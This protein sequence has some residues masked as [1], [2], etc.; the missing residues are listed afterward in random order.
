MLGAWI[1]NSSNLEFDKKG[2]ITGINFNHESFRASCRKHFW[3]LINMKVTPKLQATVRR[4]LV[5]KKNIILQQQRSDNVGFQLRK[6]SNM[7]T[8][9]SMRVGSSLETSTVLDDDES[10]SLG[11]S[12]DDNTYV[13]EVE[14]DDNLKQALRQKEKEGEIS[15]QD[16]LAEEV[17]EEILMGPLEINVGDDDREVEELLIPDGVTLSDTVDNLASQPRKG[18]TYFTSKG[19]KRR[20]TTGSLRSTDSSLPPLEYASGNRSKLS[21]GSG[22]KTAAGMDSISINSKSDLGKHSTNASLKSDKNT[23]IILLGEE[24]A[25]EVV[26]CGGDLEKDIS[27]SLRSEEIN[28]TVSPH[29]QK[30]DY[31]EDREHSQLNSHADSPLSREDVVQGRKLS[32]VEQSGGISDERKASRLSNV[33]DASVTTDSDAQGKKLSRVLENSVESGERRS[34]QL[35]GSVDGSPSQESATQSRKLSRVMNDKSYSGGRK[36]S[37]LNSHADSP[38]SRED[39]VQGRKLSRVEQS[40]GISDERKASRLSNVVDA[41]VTTDSDAQGR[42]LSR[43]LENSVESGERRSSQ[44]AGS[45]DG[46]PSQESAT[47]SRKLSRVMNDKSYS[48][49]RKQSQL[50]SHADSPLSREDVVQ[51]RKSSRVEQSGGISDERKASRLSNVVDASVTTDSDAQG[52]KLSRVLENSVESGERRSS[53]LA[54]SVDGSPSQ[55]SA[56]QSRKLSRV[57]ND[58]SYSGGRKQSQLNSHADSPLSREDVVQGRKSSRVEQSG[59]IS[60]ERKASRLSNIVDDSATTDSDAQGRK[61]SRVL[62]NSVESGER[63]SSQLA[64]S[65]DGSPSQESATQSRKLSRVMNDKSYSGG[66]KQSQLNSHA[67]SPLSCED[68]V[69]GR[70][71]SRVEESGGISDERKASRLSNVVDAS[72]TTDSDA[73]GRK[74]SRVLENSVESGERRSSQLAGSVD[75]SPSQESATQSRKLS[76]VMNDKSY[77]GGRKQSQL[78]S[79]ADSPLSREDVVQ[80]RKLSRVEESG[81]ISDERK[82]SRLSN[83]VDASVTTDS[84]AQGRKLSRVLENSVESGE[85]RSLQ[86]TGSVDG[87][88]SQESA[89][90]SRKLSRVMNDKS[91]SGGRK[92]SQLNSHADS[93]LSCEDVVQ[94]RKLSRVEESGGIS[95]ER[96]ASRLSNIVDDSATTDSDA[97]GRKLSRVLE[98]SVESG[99]RRSSQLAGS[100][101]GS[102]SQESATQSRK[103]SRVMN[104]KSYSG[105]RKQSQLN[106]HADSPLSCEDVVQGRKL[107]RVE[108]SGGISDERKASRLS[109]VVDASVTTDSDAQGRK[110]SRVLENSVESGERRSLQLTG[111]VDGSPSQESATQSR[112]LSRVMNDKSYS[113]G[114]KQSQLNSHADSPLSRED[115]VQGRKLSRVEESGG[116]SD[117]RKASRLSN[118][119]DASVTT[120]SDAQGRKLSRVLENSV[121]SG[122]R[123][124]S[125]LAGSVD[126]SPSQES[127]TQ[128]RKLSRVMN[129]KSYSGGRK[130]SQ[131]NSHADSPLSREDVVQGRKLSR[132]EQSGGIS[133]ERKASRLSNVV[134][135]SVT[136]DSDAQGRKLSRVLENSVESGERRS[137]QLAGSVDGSPSQE[138]ATQSRKLSRVMND[139]SYSGGRKQSQL[140]SHADS[141]LSRE[142]VV[143]GRK[144]SRVE[145]SGGISDERK[146]SRLSNVVDASVTTDSDAQGRKMSRLVSEKKSSLVSGESDHSSPDGCI[147]EESSDF[148]YANRKKSKIN[149]SSPRSDYQNGKKSVSSK[150][151][152][153]MSMQDIIIEQ[154]PESKLGEFLSS[155]IESD[156]DSDYGSDS[157]HEDSEYSL[158]E[159]SA[160]N[161]DLAVE[162]GELREFV[163]TEMTN[164]IGEVG[165]ISSSLKMRTKENGAS[166][167]AETENVTAEGSKEFINENF[168]SM[169]SEI[170][171]LKQLVGEMQSNMAS[172]SPVPHREESGGSEDK[173][174]LQDKGQSDDFSE[175][176]D[177]ASIKITNGDEFQMSGIFP[178]SPAVDGPKYEND[179]SS[180]ASREEKKTS[181]LGLIVEE[182]SD[183]GDNLDA[184]L[185]AEDSLQR[186][187]IYLKPNDNVHQ[188]VKADAVITKFFTQLIEKKR[189][190]RFLDSVLLRSTD[191]SDYSDNSRGLRDICEDMVRCI[192]V[193]VIDVAALLTLDLND[194]FGPL[195]RFQAAMAIVKF[196]PDIAALLVLFIYSFQSIVEVSSESFHCVNG[197][198]RKHILQRELLEAGIITCLL[199]LAHRT[200]NNA[201][202]VCEIIEAILY[203]LAD[204]PDGY[205]YAT[206]MDESALKTFSRL[207]PRLCRKSNRASRKSLSFIYT[208]CIDCPDLIITLEKLDFFQVLATCCYDL[209]NS[210]DMLTTVLCNCM[211]F[212]EQSPDCVHVLNNTGHAEIIVECLIAYAKQNSHE[213]LSHFTVV[214]GLLNALCTSCSTFC[215]SFPVHS[216]LSSIKTCLELKEGNFLF[217][218]ILSTIK[219]LLSHYPW[220]KKKCVFLKYSETL[221]P[222]IMHTGTSSDVKEELLALQRI[223]YPNWNIED[224]EAKVQLQEK[225]TIKTLE[226]SNNTVDTHSSSLTERVFDKQDNTYSSISPTPLLKDDSFENSSERGGH[227]LIP[228]APVSPKPSAERP[229]ARFKRAVSKAHALNVIS[230]VAFPYVSK[231]RLMKMKLN[232]ERLSLSQ[233]DDDS[234]RLDHREKHFYEA[235]KLKRGDDKEEFDDGTNFYDKS[236]RRDSPGANNEENAEKEESIMNTDVNAKSHRLEATSP[237]NNEKKNAVQQ[238]NSSMDNGSVLKPLIAAY[239]S[240]SESYINIL[241]HIFELCKKE[242]ATSNYDTSKALYSRI[243]ILMGGAER[244]VADP[245]VVSETLKVLLFFKFEI[246]RKV[247]ITESYLRILRHI[248]EVHRENS[249]LLVK[250]LSLLNKRSLDY[251]DK[252]FMAAIASAFEGHLD[253]EKFRKHVIKFVL[254]CITVNS[255]LRSIMLESGVCSLILDAYAVHNDKEN[256]EVLVQVILMLCADHSE[257]S[258]FFG[259][260]EANRLYLD[261]LKFYIKDEDIFHLATVPIFYSLKNFNNPDEMTMDES[262]L[263]PIMNLFDMAEKSGDD[264]ARII[265]T[266]LKLIRELCTVPCARKLFMK[267]NFSLVVSQYNTPS[268]ST[269]ICKLSKSISKR[270][271][272]E[273]E[274]GN[275]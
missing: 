238:E 24:R 225:A 89:T 93:P 144:L 180:N 230:K 212:V 241:S 7:V 132:V 250:V 121:E 235:Q 85:R 104:D 233:F 5:R 23:D 213:S 29:S 155:M 208:L 223:I 191:N 53:Q 169:K 8:K 15:R 75:G 202:F 119:V 174:G 139:K 275:K 217:R 147:K 13:G 256:L 86:L 255:S 96:K 218:I 135:A 259:T 33:V 183:C 40:G 78:N 173:I 263:L 159:D 175:S 186:D 240:G 43:V 224:E 222:H 46:S 34:S 48:G 145:Q 247:E 127:A 185:D 199:S 14:E 107:S 140:N 2:K 128:S 150:R 146:A 69:Q 227:V 45:V 149:V 20:G 38:L 176:T 71:L 37:Q 198:I 210:I 243:D 207:L 171:E 95:D 99:E 229:Q 116:I 81:G 63:R 257:N 164:F 22:V 122:E 266:I 179:C 162:I 236:E 124:S 117:E 262:C 9:G 54:G 90:Q 193:G 264:G 103:L 77:S 206:I 201:D 126:G 58:K 92:Q 100:V 114:R 268:F 234:L 167:R 1:L 170:L 221:I 83:V 131:L 182:K 204:M 253:D 273:F 67:D 66:R 219:S 148:S 188:S 260:T 72:V 215:R 216:F 56:T 138:S 187:L 27:M 17:P 50:N 166:R 118:V 160:A 111:S 165:A 76:R 181:P 133:D 172:N 74:L 97:Q 249:D 125:Q 136:T 4:F 79:H 168:E 98:N 115:V 84:D 52:R 195:N 152:P 10:K 269:K 32:R 274:K 68:V 30:L 151:K 101:D 209:V 88:P 246:K 44:L 130:Q 190:R 55:E 108:E 156:D 57:M 110:L 109:N 184:L 3:L 272:R 244:H 106:S 39:V 82:A 189:R 220:L 239:K 161:Q 157:G 49:G 211:L 158:P 252:K 245:N 11:S 196:Y 36:Q 41:S 35:A 237:N 62:E 120:D 65:V 231:M 178:L 102:P 19:I 254:Q 153:S 123:R 94:G 21:T 61:L 267:S 28:Q 12:P 112:K 242:V 59:G 87:S 70:K 16:K 18:F 154:D 25:E 163:Q 31:S 42:K 214:S 26:L 113:G 248:L 143:Q 91:Y 200:H 192:H 271:S 129:D 205:T 270:L 232:M 226:I 60:D 6:Q 51:G 64:G 251:I 142:D 197:L 47:Q 194:F 203:I 258:A 261:C 228:S 177:F 137:S 141:P 73:Q 80:G 134:D 105:G 265:E